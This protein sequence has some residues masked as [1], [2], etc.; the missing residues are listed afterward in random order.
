MSEWHWDYRCRLMAI[1]SEARDQSLT[2][3]DVSKKLNKLEEELAGSF[4]GINY[5]ASKEK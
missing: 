3:E 2:D 5:P 1:L 4:P